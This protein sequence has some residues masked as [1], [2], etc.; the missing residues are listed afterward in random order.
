MGKRNV[1]VLGVRGMLG[2]AVFYTLSKKEDLDVFGT[3][4]NKEE[5]NDLENVFES[6]LIKKTRYDVDAGNMDTMQKVI[7]DIRPDIVINCIGLIKQVKAGKEPLPNITLN[8]QL[9]HL[10]A[11]FCE[12]N[13]ARMIHV[14]TDCVFNGEKGNYVEEDMPDAKDFYGL[15]KYLGEVDYPHCVTIRTSIIG[16][17]IETNLA[18][19]DWFLSQ[20]NAVK[21]FTGA[22]YTG[23]PTV[24]IAEII[25]KFIMPN[26]ELTGLYH[27]SSDPISKYEL[28][29]LVA[30]QYE[31]DISIEPYDEFHCDRSLV[32]TRFREKTGYVPSAW[33]ELVA[34]LHDHYITSG[35]Y[36]ATNTISNC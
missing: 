36:T 11:K 30:A 15:T 20:D 18:L 22:I 23:L 24:E 13:G 17:E 4:R 5:F 27:V 14:S 28:L 33:P 21:G 10:L 8:A 35:L 26:P 16:H 3:V 7:E 25:H 9:P 32:S 2:H 1:L 31:K 12:A 6:D 29:K 19:V 34:Q